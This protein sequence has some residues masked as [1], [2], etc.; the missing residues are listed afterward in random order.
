MKIIIT[1]TG[2]YP[3]K[4]NIEDRVFRPSSDLHPCRGCFKCWTETPGVCCQKDDARY[5]GVL[6]SK[7]DE[8]IIISRCFH[9]GYSEFVKMVMERTLPFLQPGFEEK[10]GRTRH[11]AR[12]DTVL[13][14]KVYFYEEN[15][16]NEE[17]E[18]AEKM[19]KETMDAYHGTVKE[20]RWYEDAWQIGGIE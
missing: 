14:A 2:T 19:V 12:Y 9:G 5:L 4:I 8:L 13:K 16:T 20:I 7:C 15:M 17:K 6:L 1:D 10:D 11:L 3:G 18:L